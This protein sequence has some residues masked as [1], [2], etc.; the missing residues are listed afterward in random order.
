MQADGGCDDDIAKR[1]FDPERQQRRELWQ[2]IKL[3][4][5]TVEKEKWKTKEAVSAYCLKY[6]LE[7]NYT[8]KQVL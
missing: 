8:S 5:P 1:L 6:K 2:F 7:L 4:A 3:V